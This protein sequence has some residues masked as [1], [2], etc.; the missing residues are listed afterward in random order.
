[1]SD[2]CAVAGGGAG[3]ASLEHLARRESR[4]RGGK[5]MRGVRTD[6]AIADTECALDAPRTRGRGRAGAPPRRVFLRF[7]PT[8]VSV[9]SLTFGALCGS[10]VVWCVERVLIA[11]SWY[12]YCDL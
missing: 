5:L 11:S 7:C 9:E 10:G 1:M 6:K 3:T 4:G 12:T 8:Y 2:A